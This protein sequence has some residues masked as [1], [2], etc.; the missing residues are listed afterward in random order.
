[1]VF[2][3]LVGA[4]LIAGVRKNKLSYVT[5]SISQVSKNLVGMQAGIGTKSVTFVFVENVG[6]GGNGAIGKSMLTRPFGVLYNYG[7]S[8]TVCVAF[9]ICKGGGVGTPPRAVG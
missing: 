9:V 4:R 1:M 5:S 7:V 6:D 8:A 3:G 2:V